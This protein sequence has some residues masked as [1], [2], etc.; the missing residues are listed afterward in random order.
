MIVEK[1]L[2]KYFPLFA[3]PGIICF[4]LAFLIP[5]IMGIYLSFCEFTNVT[6]AKWVGLD[7]YIT[8]FTVDNY[9]SSALWLTIKFTI[10][11]VITI[12]FFALHFYLLGGLREQMF[13]EQYFL[14]LTL[15]V[16]SFW[17]GSGR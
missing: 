11:S 13:S 10:V 3:L 8:A 9:F 5:M 1:S 16:E 6:N 7:N 12:N 2:R 14:C 4:L 17:D 15:S